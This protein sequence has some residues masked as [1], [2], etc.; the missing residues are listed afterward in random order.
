MIQRFIIQRHT[1]CLVKMGRSKREE[2]EGK[3]YLTMFYGQAWRGICS[4]NQDKGFWCSSADNR[5]SMHAWYTKFFFGV[6]IIVLVVVWVE[7]QPSHLH[8][9]CKA[10]EYSN[11]NGHHL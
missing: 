6:L 4:S 7:H 3:W 5:I 1:Q 9:H 10:K 8:T 11:T 2:G